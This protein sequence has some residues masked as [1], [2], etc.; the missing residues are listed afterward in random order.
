[1]LEDLSK[2][3]ENS[4]IILHACAH[5]PTGVDPTPADWAK[6][7]KVM[8]E[9]KLFPLFDSAYQGFASGDLEKDSYAVRYFV[10]QGME[11][12]CCQS[13]AKNFGLY[14]KFYRV[15][16]VLYLLCRLERKSTPLL[17]VL[18]CNFR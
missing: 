18:C 14:S 2:A 6:I 8:K 4:V 17:K 10:D 15:G 13:F 16:L 1:M 11:I 7:L 3:P 5:N 12:V 9:R